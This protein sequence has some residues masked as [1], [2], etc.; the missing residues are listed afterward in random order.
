MLRSK[1]KASQHVREPFSWDVCP[2]HADTRVSALGQVFTP[3]VVLV[4]KEAKFRK[5]KMV[6]LK[7]NRIT[8]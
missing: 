4:V 5:R 2:R 7:L 1:R 3:L 6:R 8:L